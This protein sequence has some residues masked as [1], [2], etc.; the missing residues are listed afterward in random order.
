MKKH[1]DLFLSKQVNDPI[2]KEYEIQTKGHDGNTVR[3]NF[4]KNQ[5]NMSETKVFNFSYG[6]AE[7]IIFVEPATE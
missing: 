1:T 6:K 4:I 2:I 7:Q 3:P 5:L